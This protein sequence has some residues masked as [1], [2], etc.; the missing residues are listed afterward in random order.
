M[1]SM[2]QSW[3]KAGTSP[4]L[5]NKSNLD[6]SSE[7]HP[8]EQKTMYSYIRTPWAGIECST[9]SYQPDLDCNSTVR[10]STLV[11]IEM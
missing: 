6:W 7:G 5:F 4:D 3:L 11:A 10:F 1:R 9:V 8:C 2:M